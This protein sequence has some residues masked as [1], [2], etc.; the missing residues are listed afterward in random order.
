MGVRC[1]GANLHYDDD[2]Y[3]TEKL[4]SVFAGGSAIRAR[5]G[6]DA[7]RPNRYTMSRLLS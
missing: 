1:N 4:T 7:S 2:E 3:V 6:E 5:I